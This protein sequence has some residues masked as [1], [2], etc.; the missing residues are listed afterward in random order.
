MQEEAYTKKARQIVA[1]ARAEAEQLGHGFVG[2]E[3]LILAMLHDGSNVGAAILRTHRVHLQRFQQAV[4]QEI[5]RES[6]TSLTDDAYTPALRR[7]LHS[8]E[9]LRGRAGDVQAVSSEDLLLAVL[10]DEHCGAAML[11]REMGISLHALRD[12]CGKSSVLSPRDAN[13]GFPQFDKKACP[14]LA[15]YAK[16]LTEP[17]TADRTDPL[18]GRENEI[19]QTM[20][21]LMR[22]TKNNPVLIGDAGVGKTAIVEGLAKRILAGTVPPALRKKVILSLDLTSLLAGA[23]YRGDFEERLKACMDEAANDS[24]IILFIDEIHMI[25]GTG[26]AEGA[27]DAANAMKPRLARGELQLIGATT[28]DEYRKVIEKDSALA[29]RFQPVRIPE[30]TPAAAIEMLHGLRPQYERFHALDIGSD[31]IEAAVEYSVRYLHDRALPDKALDLLDEACAACR[32]KPGSAEHADDWDLPA[33]HTNDIEHIVSEKTGIPVSKLT[34]SEAERLLHLE[35]TI[36]ARVIGQ[37]EAIA[38]VAN[39]VRRSRSGLRGHSRP[40]GAFLFLG[41]TGTG[42][43]ELAKAIADVLFDGSCIRMDMSEYMEKHT[44]SKLIGAPPGYVGFDEGSSLVERVRRSPYSVILFDEMEKAHPD[45][46]SLLLQILEDGVLTDGQGN[47]ADF[48]DSLIILTSNLGAEKLQNGVIGFADAAQTEQAQQDTILSVLKK[49]IRPELFHRLDAAIVFRRLSAP[50]YE[51]ITAL[52][53]KGLAERAR[54][55]GTELTWT[56][57]A[58]RLLMQNADTEHGGARAIRT[59]MT[60]RVEPLLADSLLRKR[61]GAKLLCVRGGAMTVEETVP[62]GSKE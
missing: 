48:T 43:T 53:L 31:A 36:S 7:I 9:K 58:V 10:K 39:A 40:I 4:L 3:H 56:P 21:I 57:E 24:Q 14:T 35:E 23:K 45:V 59:E 2:S 62:A 27:I 22:R 28:A 37:D 30:P 46:L 61:A 29:R 60:Q 1:G 44:A 18:I 19:H 54:A 47:K 26:A 38:A 11:L 20:Q 33:V 42:K 32:L 55:C 25:A 52:Q 16:N 49:S 34:E 12:A 17:L 6:P 8:A 5:G 41:M 51:K 50:D 15:K 13:D